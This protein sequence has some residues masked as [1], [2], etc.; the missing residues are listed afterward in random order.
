MKRVVIRAEDKNC[1]EGRTPLTPDDSRELLADCGM[2]VQKSDIRCFSEEAYKLAGCGICEDYEDADIVIGVKEIPK[3]K[4]LPEKI[5]LFF[6]HCIKG[7][8]NGIQLVKKIMEGNS[9]LIDYERIVDKN[10]QRL[11]AFGKYA[12]HAGAVDTLWLLGEQL[13]ARGYETAFGKC[14]R[15]I[16]YKDLKH[17]KA[18]LRSIGEELKEQN[19]K[20]N[21][22]AV[23][24]G[25]FGYG[26]VSKG[27]EEILSC[28]PIN[29]IEPAQIKDVY[30]NKDTYD[31]N[32]FLC[33]FRSDH[34]VRH[35]ENKSFTKT[36]YYNKPTEYTSDFEQYVK[37][38][39]VIINGLYWDV[40]G[41]SIVTWDMLQ[42]LYQ[43]EN[44][45]RLAV[46]ADIS[47]DKQGA[48]ECNMKY[49]DIDHPHYYI[50]PLKKSIS[51]FPKDHAV[52]V[53]AVD[54]FPAELSL[55][56]SVY[57]SSILKGYLKDIVSADYR[58]PLDSNGLPQEIRKAV[59]VY[60]GELT[61]D[62]KYL[63]MYF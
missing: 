34:L 39:S 48:I 6:S 57:F 41:P 1:W 10:N 46:I 11:I 42:R 22:P 55:D 16:H 54:N 18:E 56:A 7:Q 23:I 47:C 26:S 50:D 5:Y 32:L 33:I 8:N 20:Q 13:K 4:L 51:D 21:S 15:A 25:I 52:A 35:K 58:L 43:N 38:L 12:G 63:E 31:S 62:Y 29:V 40:N 37:Y 53:L 61:P 44:D 14:K 19:K 17:A 59:I 30:E 27:A 24:I 3:E 60:N 2:Y 9:T 45:P 49:T 36:D 28:L